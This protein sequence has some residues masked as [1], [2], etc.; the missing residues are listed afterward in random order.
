MLMLSRTVPSCHNAT[1]GGPL[2]VQKIDIPKIAFHIEKFA[3]LRNN[4][5]SQN[6]G[7]LAKK[8]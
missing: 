3:Q 1:Q 8:P 2:H 5:L 6:Q 4:P 7:Y